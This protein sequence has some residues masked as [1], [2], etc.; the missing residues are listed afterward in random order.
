MNDLF[1][2]RHS[3]KPSSNRLQLRLLLLSHL[4]RVPERK[5]VLGVARH[6]RYGRGRGKSVAARS[7]DESLLVKPQ[8]KRSSIQ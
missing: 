2:D 4:E 5:A 3:R 1:G 7:W 8:V 6:G